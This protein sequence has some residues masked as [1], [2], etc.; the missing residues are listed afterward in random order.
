MDNNGGR[1]AYGSRS[2]LF[3]SGILVSAELIQ[4]YLN[5]LNNFGEEF[6]RIDLEPIKRNKFIMLRAIRRVPQ[7]FQVDFS[8]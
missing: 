1:E 4:D 5:F 2:P 3:D 7:F 6:I 8:T